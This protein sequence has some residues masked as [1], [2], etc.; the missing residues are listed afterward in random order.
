MHPTVVQAYSDIQSVTYL[1]V[2]ASTDDHSDGVLGVDAIL[3]YSSHFLYSSEAM[4]E[5]TFLYVSRSTC[6]LHVVNNGHSTPHHS[7]GLC[8]HAFIGL[9]LKYLHWNCN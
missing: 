8:F 6:F 2:S 5:Q 9:T 3:L 1:G 7:S 4:F